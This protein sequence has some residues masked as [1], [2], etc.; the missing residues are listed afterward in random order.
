MDGATVERLL[1]AS[2]FPLLF[3]VGLHPAKTH[4]LN[5]RPIRT[6]AKENTTQGELFWIV[7][8]RKTHLERRIVAGRNPSPESIVWG[9]KE[10]S[11][12]LRHRSR[13]I[14]VHFSVPLLFLFSSH[15]CITILQLKQIIVYLFSF[16]II[17]IYISFNIICI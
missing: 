16:S 8:H 17:H 9:K 13:T 3:T 11:P 5:H 7:F 10:E 2:L 6:I 12:H 4:P 14:P 15:K 1:F